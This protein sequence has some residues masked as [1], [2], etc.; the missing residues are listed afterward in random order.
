MESIIGLAKSA[1]QSIGAIQP[2]AITAVAGLL[3]RQFE[4][5]VLMTLGALIVNQL[6]SIARL[7]LA[8]EAS[9]SGTVNARWNTFLGLQMQDFLAAFIGFGLVI[10]LVY[11]LKLLVKKKA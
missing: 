9:F 1:L 3:L 6:V 2:L 5:I 11:A 4:Q 10:A 7:S 8:E